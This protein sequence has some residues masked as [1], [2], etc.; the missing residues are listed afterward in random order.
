G[1]GFRAVPRGYDPRHVSGQP[2]PCR[3]DRQSFQKQSELF[4]IIGQI[5]GKTDPTKAWHKIL[6]T[7]INRQ[8]PKAKAD[9]IVSYD[10]MFYPCAAAMVTGAGEDFIV[11][12]RLDNQASCF[13]A[14]EA[15]SKNPSGHH[16]MVLIT[17]HEE[18]GSQSAY[19]AASN[20]LQQTLGQ[21]WGQDLPAVLAKSFLISCDAAHG[22]HPN[23]VGKYEPSHLT[24]LNQGPVIKTN[25]NQR[26]T[27]N[28]LSSAIFTQLAQQAKVGV[29]NFVTHGDISCGSTIGPT[30]ATQLGVTAVDVG[31]PTW[32]MHSSTET[33][34]TRDLEQLI[35]V[36]GLYAQKPLP[37]IQ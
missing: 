23:Y 30:L 31:I 2:G 18:C 20:F 28:D 3:K 7:Q 24:Y 32:A 6:L 37:K 19:G 25:F 26:Y 33:M 5:S 12:P 4:P 9:K 16:N 13:A 29:Q 8:Y 22:V 35:K 14:I 17:D 27:S 21:I 1:R 36:L 15:L 34:G 11:A 10:L